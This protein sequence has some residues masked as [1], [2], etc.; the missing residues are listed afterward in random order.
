MSGF[1]RFFTG[2]EQHFFRA[3]RL[4]QSGDITGIPCVAGHIVFRGVFI[5]LI[6]PVKIAF[7]RGG[8]RRAGS[9]FGGG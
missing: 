8:A 7:D 4:G 9:V 6:R 2:D 1:G 3:K 5:T